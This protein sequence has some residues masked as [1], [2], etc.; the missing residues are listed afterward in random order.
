MRKI[1]IG[2]LLLGCLLAPLQAHADPDCRAILLHDVKA[3]GGSEISEKA[4][5]IIDFI[6]LENVNDDGSPETYA[7]HGGSFY[8]ASDIKLLNCHINKKRNDDGKGFSYDT[9]LD[10]TPENAAEILRST[11]ESK[12]SALGLCSACASNAAQSYLNPQDS[13]CKRAVK[14]ILDGDTELVSILNGSEIC[15]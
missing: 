9:V 5:S 10:D 7:V 11:I 13:A 15:N 8:K 1:R 3:F 4:G 12:L 6:H 14:S 2:G